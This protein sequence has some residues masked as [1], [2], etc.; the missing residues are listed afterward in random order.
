MERAIILSDGRTVTP[1]ELYLQPV[2]DLRESSADHKTFKDV[3]RE[4]VEAAER[5]MIVDALRKNDWK[6]SRVAEALGI[7]YKT[8]RIK[9]K[10]YR[11]HRP[12]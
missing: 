12:M 11:I 5:G 10:K 6:K 9:I 4:A 1:N 7:D 8:L 2:V 3:G